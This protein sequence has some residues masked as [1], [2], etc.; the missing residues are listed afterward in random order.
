MGYID[1]RSVRKS[2]SMFVH[3]YVCKGLSRSDPISSR[4]GTRKIGDVTLAG[5]HESPLG[6][7]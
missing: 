1:F 7:C 5:Q 6:I 2:L 3:L 4:F